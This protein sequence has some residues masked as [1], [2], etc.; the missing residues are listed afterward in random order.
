M[1]SPKDPLMRDELDAL[2]RISQGDAGDLPNTYKARLLMLGYVEE[3]PGGVRI[4]ERGRD[5]LAGKL[6]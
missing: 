3:H 1:A 6:W 5:R 4:T 2:R